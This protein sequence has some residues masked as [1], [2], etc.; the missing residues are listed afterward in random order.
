VKRLWSTLETL[1]WISDHRPT[2]SGRKCEKIILSCSFGGLCLPWD[3][4]LAEG[5]F[6]R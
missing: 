5:K 4:C 1:S 2:E 3:L 6:R